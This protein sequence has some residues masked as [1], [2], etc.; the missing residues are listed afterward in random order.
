M[1]IKCNNANEDNTM[2]S[3]KYDTEITSQLYAERTILEE[4]TT[5]TV[6]AS[7]TSISDTSRTDPGSVT[8]I[9]SSK[10][11]N[12]KTIQKNEKG[13]DKIEICIKV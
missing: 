4:E 8:G 1:E 5:D 12:A 7:K 2:T 9:N 10:A 11:D 6:F 13:N 3:D